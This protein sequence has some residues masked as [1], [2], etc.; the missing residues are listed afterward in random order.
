MKGRIKAIFFDIDGTLVSFKS[1][2]VPE[3]AR[4]AIARLREQGVKVFIA[5]GR[6]MKHVAIVNDIEVDGYITVNGGYC[7]T[8][9]GEVIFE[10]A[11]PRATV[12]RVIDLSEQ[13]GFDL[14]VM[15]HE[16]MYVSSMGERVKK[17]ASMINIMP[18]VA[19]VRAI[20]A[21]QPVVQM[22]P[23]ISR[24]LEQEIMPLLPDCVGSRWIETFMDL[25]VR[26]VDKSLGI[27]QVMNYYGLTMAEAMAFGDGGNDLPMVRDAAVGVAMG[28]ACDELKAVADYITSSVDEDGVSRALEHFGL[29]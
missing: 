16:D 3:S 19:D 14:N 21:T 29:I 18:T 22:C 25:N 26:G 8:F 27:Q 17:I 10:S 9:A 1:H 23:Y 20:A 13:Y 15:T 28:N 4:R 24:E 6:L 12:E 7:I 5:T 11:F 2:T